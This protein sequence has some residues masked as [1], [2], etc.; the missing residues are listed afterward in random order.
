[1]CNLSLGVR[2]T[3]TLFVLKKKKEVIIE[4]H[5]HVIFKNLV[6]IKIVI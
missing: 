5:V 6:E 4:L 2:D 3:H 1:M